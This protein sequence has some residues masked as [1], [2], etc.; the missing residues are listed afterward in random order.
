HPTPVAYSMLVLLSFL[1]A[2][3]LLPNNVLGLW[4]I[5]RNLEIGTTF[6]KLAPTFDIKVNLNDA[7]QDLLDAV[8]R[9]K[10]YLQTDKL[11][12]LVVGRGQ[13]DSSAIGQALELPSLAISLS[14]ET[15]PRS[16]AVE[17]TLPIKTRSE[18]YSLSVPSDGS[19][20]TLAANSTLGLFRG[21][22]TF[23]QL[24]Y[25]LAGVTYT[26]QAPINIVNDIS[27][28]KRTLDAMSWVK[29]GMFT[30]VLLGCSMCL[31]LKYQINTF[32]WHS[33]DSQSFPLDIPGFSE[34]AAKGAYSMNEIYSTTDV[35]DIVSY[36]GAEIDTP[37]H[38]AAIAASHPEHIACSQASPWSQFAG[39]P[40]AGQLRLTSAATTNFTAELISSMAKT[41]PSTLFSTGGDEVNTNC[42]LQDPQTQAD[43]ASSGRTLEQALSS[44][45]QAT[46]K[47]LID[48][49]KTPVVW[50]EMLLEHNVTLPMTAAV[51]CV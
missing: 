23:S 4:P 49:G 24:W 5:P 36:A 18:G 38:T 34:L 39:E 1:G 43:L 8:S 13:N 46:H 11:Q 22:T 41:L 48:L 14:S 26:Y 32:H 30:L 10:D 28:I 16:I 15:E 29:V 19:P 44:F 25:D 51:M 17:A 35:Q 50:E 31:F 7:P 12:R 42:Y 20:A 47:P 37:G 45:V 9:T 6:L 21:L 33:V 27:D 40:P 3:V 2:A